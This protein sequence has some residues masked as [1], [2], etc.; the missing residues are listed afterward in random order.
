MHVLALVGTCKKGIPGKP[1]DVHGTIS[2]D[3]NLN[4]TEIV[5]G[6]Q[7]YL[8]GKNGDNQFPDG[9]QR[10]CGVCVCVCV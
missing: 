8:A 3:G 5:G 7:F 9:Q 4:S 10:T 6:F 2:P 1:G